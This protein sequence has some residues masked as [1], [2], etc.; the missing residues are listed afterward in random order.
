MRIVIGAALTHPKS[1][2][3][4]IRPEIVQWHSLASVLRD[5]GFRRQPVTISEKVSSEKAARYLDFLRVVPI[6]TRELLGKE[7]LLVTGELSEFLEQFPRDHS[8]EDWPRELRPGSRETEYQDTCQ[9][10]AS[11]SDE[12]EILDPWLGEKI[13]KNQ[14][15]L[16]LI[17][18]LLRDTSGTI[19][20]VTRE[21]KEYSTNSLD[22][23]LQSH[24]DSALQD[25]MA[26]SGRIRASS[27]SVELKRYTNETRFIHN[28]AIRFLF[29]NGVSSDHVLEHGVEAFG[30][31]VI[32]ESDLSRMSSASFNHRKARLAAFETRLSSSSSPNQQDG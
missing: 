31:K 24:L 4:E 20:I 2:E 13:F 17:S 6:S 19:K 10:L 32:E 5:E 29:S 21:P 27:I 28:R 25:L 23:L 7:E 3:R 12:I 14:N 26:K 11:L 22:N 1:L 9:V 15:Q 18:N 30:R 8:L 16:W